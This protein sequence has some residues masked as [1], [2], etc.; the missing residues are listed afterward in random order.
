M[1]WNGY[2]GAGSMVDSLVFFDD[3]LVL[4]SLL[5]GE[6]SKFDHYAVD[7]FE[8]HAD[9]SF[10]AILSE[11]RVV[12]LWPRTN[13]AGGVVTVGTVTAATVS[14]SCSPLVT[15]LECECN[16]DEDWCIFNVRV[17][18]DRLKDLVS[19]GGL[20]WESLRY[21]SANRSSIGPNGFTGSIGNNATFFSGFRLSNSS[22]SLS[23][24]LSSGPAHS[25]GS[26]AFDT[27]RGVSSLARDIDLW[28]DQGIVNVSAEAAAR[29]R[30]LVETVRTPSPGEPCCCSAG[31]LEYVGGVC[32]GEDPNYCHYTVAEQW[33]GEGEG[34]CPGGWI[35]DGL[36]EQTGKVRCKL[37]ETVIASECDGLPWYEAN[38]L[39][40]PD[41]IFSQEIGT[42]S[43]CSPVSCGGECDPQLGIGCCPGCECV[44]TSFDGEVYHACS[45][46]CLVGDF[47]DVPFE[48]NGQLVDGFCC[49]DVGCK[50]PFKDGCCYDGAAVIGPAADMDEDCQ[51]INQNY[52]FDPCPC[53]E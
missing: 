10:G 6:D 19:F 8:V 17:S 45:G 47:C 5:E 4:G 27:I 7:W 23:D 32:P 16:L 46:P 41:W 26:D 53:G 1:F 3:N 2:Q 35:F 38:G 28:R 24:I 52:V 37:C 15:P 20:H 30:A 14:S 36:N 25:Y 21:I 13:I 12:C 43:S 39:D 33:I 11:R 44:E 49:P 34:S 29:R 48:Y 42:T 31:D 40:G 51:L 9:G 50:H 22:P 18:Y